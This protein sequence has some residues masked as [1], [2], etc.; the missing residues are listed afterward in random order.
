MTLATI[1]GVTLVMDT[2]VNTRRTVRQVRLGLGH[3]VLNWLQ[4]DQ[5]K[6]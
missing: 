4:N 5:Q 3:Q 2:A 1:L 6:D